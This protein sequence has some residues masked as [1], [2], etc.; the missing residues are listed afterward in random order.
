MKGFRVG[1][2][3]HALAHWRD[4]GLRYLVVMNLSIL[5]PSLRKGLA[6]NAPLFR[7]LRALKKL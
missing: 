4:H 3:T 1:V 2:G 7:I 6:A 5:L